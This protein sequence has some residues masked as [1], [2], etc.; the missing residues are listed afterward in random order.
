ML[1]KYSL[2]SLGMMWLSLVFVWREW[3]DNYVHIIGC[4]VGQGD[5]FIVTHGFNQILIDTGPSKSDFLACVSRHVPYWD[6]KIELVV[7]SHPQDDHYGGLAEI[8]NAYTVTAIMVPDIINPTEQFY[9]LR[10]MVQD[11]GIRVI[12]GMV[13]NVFKLDE[14]KIDIVWPKTS[15]AEG[16]AW[17]ASNTLNSDDEVV[18]NNFDLNVASIVLIL[19]YGEVSVLFTGDVGI[20][21]ELS[22]VNSGLIPRVNV[23]KVPHHGS[24][25]SSSQELI[26]STKP[27]YGI[28]SV[29]SQN[30]FGHPNREIIDNYES[31]G[32]KILR[33]DFGGE[34][35][36][37]SDGYAI[38]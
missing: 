4:D 29:G 21:E 34:V 13:G 10:Q 14:L 7:I 20:K 31:L 35:L 9:N 8:L 28:V 38:R 3:P 26:N 17:I 32:V 36:L 37:E 18:Q 11:Q 22:M 12:E 33:T 30:K 19:R 16:K 6:R 24:K 27:E 25:T 1:A 23:I 5:G 2:V 15:F